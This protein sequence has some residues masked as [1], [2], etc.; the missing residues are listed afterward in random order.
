MP[1]LTARWGQ[2]GFTLIELL[3]TVAIAAIVLSFGF[4]GFSQLAGRT[5]MTG[6]AN[7]L[8]AHLQLARTEAVKLGTRVTVCP[9]AAGSGCDAASTS[10]ANGYIVAVGSGGTVTQVLR[11]VDADEM[12]GIAVTKNGSSTRIEFAPD[13]SAE[14][15]N[16]TLKICNPRDSSLIRQVVVSPMGR[17]Y[18]KC[19]DPGAYAC[20][21]S[22][23]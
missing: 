10:W 18:V 17:S 9:S 12:R 14:G 19:N 21:E 16:A 1:H 20:A 13:G 6:A 15:Y 7:S 2:P 8:I 23:P 11:R 22:C 5:K 4:A 3:T